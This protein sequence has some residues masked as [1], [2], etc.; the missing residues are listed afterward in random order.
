MSEVGT[1]VEFDVQLTKADLRQAAT[2]WQF[3]RPMTWLFLVIGTL[4]LFS[5]VAE[6]VVHAKVLAV[7]LGVGLIWILWPFLIP[8]LQTRKSRQGPG[9]LAAAH[10]QVDDERLRR[11]TKE[12]AVEFTWSSLFGFRNTARAILILTNK[13]CFFVIPKRSFP[14]EAELLRFTSIVSSHLAKK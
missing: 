3:R 13:T 5:S 12:T 4:L 1:A 11:T 9:A 10:Y 8:V 2:A 6:S 7:P 14:D